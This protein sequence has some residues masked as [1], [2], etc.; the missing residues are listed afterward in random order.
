MKR[1][2]PAADRNKLPILEVLEAELPK[3]GTVLE[4]ASGSGQHA[5]FFAG[6]LPGVVW[7]PSD[8]D[9]AALASIDEY[10][11][12]TALPN[13]KRPLA[14]DVLALPWPVDAVSAVVCI[15]MIHISPWAAT[16]ALLEGARAL[17][18]QGAP[19]VLYGPYVIDGDFGA[20]SN[21][22]FDQRLRGENPEWGVRELR[23]VEREANAVGLHLSRVVPRP[24][25]NHVVVFRVR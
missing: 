8:R 9:P 6:H 4:I 20:D 1:H 18:G 13:L 15:N 19:L 5:A 14:V 22:A 11:T 2:A 21:V 10:V 17:L 25:N 7:Q 16:L 3:S 12:D 23:Q 24:A